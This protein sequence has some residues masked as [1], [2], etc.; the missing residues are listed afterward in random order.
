MITSL[1]AHLIPLG[2][3]DVEGHS[4][5]PDTYNW[6]FCINEMIFKILQPECCSYGQWINQKLVVFISQ[7]EKYNPIVVH[8]YMG[9]STNDLIKN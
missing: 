1:T 6:L 7:G 3:R 4:Y 2:M 8:N 9:L 5:V